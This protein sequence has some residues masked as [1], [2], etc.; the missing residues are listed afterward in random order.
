[1]LR[2]LNNKHCLGHE[3]TFTKEKKCDMI[4]PNFGFWRKDGQYNDNKEG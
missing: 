2:K 1:M 3:K 4:R